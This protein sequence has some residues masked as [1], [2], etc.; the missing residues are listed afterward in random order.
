MAAVAMLASG[1]E[2]AAVVKSPVSVTALI[3]MSPEAAPI[4]AP[5]AMLVSASLVVFVIA[6]PTT[7][8]EGSA[9]VT[10]FLI[11]VD[12][13]LLTSDTAEAVIS[14]V[15]SASASVLAAPPAV[16]FP[17]TLTLALFEVWA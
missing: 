2:A 8:A 5:S 16:T 10:L 6:I 7:S 14:I 1:A 15:L 12:A 11:A 4:W 17:A 9:F 3:F 13:V